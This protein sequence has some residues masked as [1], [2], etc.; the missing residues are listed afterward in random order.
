V[1]RHAWR[2]EIVGNR[3]DSNHEMIISDAMPTEQLSA[4]FIEYWRD[5]GKSIY[6]IDRLERAAIEAI[7]PAMSMAT[8]TNLVEVGV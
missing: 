8:I 3:S 2:A 4:I 5:D 6:A 7:S 1:L